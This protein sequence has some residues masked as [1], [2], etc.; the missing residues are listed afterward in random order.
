MEEVPS[1]KKVFHLLEFYVILNQISQNILQFSRRHITLL[2]HTVR[3]LIQV[4][5][6]QKSTAGNYSLRA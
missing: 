3:R 1:V 4:L 2:C 6:R 5:L